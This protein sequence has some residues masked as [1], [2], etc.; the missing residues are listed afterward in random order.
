M[1][2]TSVLQSFI[3]YLT[4]CF[5]SCNKPPCECDFTPV[6]FIQ[7]QLVNQQGQN[8]LSGPS[9]LYQVD[10]LKILNQ[11]FNLDINNASVEKGVTDSTAV[12][13][14]FYVYETKNYIYYNSQT[15]VDSIE[16]N[17]VRK[18]GKCCETPMNYELVDAV[19]FNNTLVNPVK[20]TYYFVK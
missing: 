13:I 7:I 4:L 17:W 3:L 14:N 10:S 18:V 20:G 8:L 2:L 9:A 12:L 1:K 11:P 16:I 5:I 19:K 6:N 15:P